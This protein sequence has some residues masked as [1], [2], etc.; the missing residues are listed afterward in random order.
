MTDI[1]GRVAG[2]EIAQALSLPFSLGNPAELR[3]ICKES[4]LTSANVTTFQGKSRFPDVKTIVLADLK[5]WFPLAGNELSDSQIDDVINNAEFELQ[6]YITDD[7]S[8]E[9]PVSV[10]FINYEKN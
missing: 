8:L 3:A 5:G 7:G 6:E 2:D 4:G 9:F 1:F 10:H